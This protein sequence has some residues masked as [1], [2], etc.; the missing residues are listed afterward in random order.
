MEELIQGAEERNFDVITKKTKKLSSV[1]IAT[2]V[3]GVI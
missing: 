2:N 3:D 1:T